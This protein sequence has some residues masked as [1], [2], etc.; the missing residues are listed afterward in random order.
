M[1]AKWAE[2][3]PYMQPDANGRTWQDAANGLGDKS[4]GMYLLGN[5]VTSN[6]DGATQQD[7]IDDIDFFLFPEI[8]AE[9]GQDAIEAPID[10]F[11]MAAAPANVDGAKALLGSLGTKEAIGAY[12]GID[13]SVV[14][15]NGAA[16][17]SGYNSLQQKAAELV[18]GSKYIAQFL[19]RDTDPSFASDVVG[20]GIADFL[21]DPTQIDTILDTIEAQKATYTFE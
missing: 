14:A 1:F 15:A 10:G 7:I 2:L 11:M 19:D 5:F 12:I 8:N 13:P 20:I 3:L 21:A 17:T 9:H 4:V 18:G 6:F 16:D